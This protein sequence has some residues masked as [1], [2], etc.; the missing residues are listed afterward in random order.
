[1]SELTRCELDELEEDLKCMSDWAPRTHYLVGRLK[2][3]HAAQ[4]ET[5][6]QQA[7]RIQAVE[8]ERDLWFEQAHYLI[9]NADAPITW[10]EECLN[11]KQ[12]LA[13]LEAE[14]AA[15]KAVET[16]PSIGTGGVAM[17]RMNAMEIVTPEPPSC[18]H[19][20]LFTDPTMVEWV[21]GEDDHL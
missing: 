6:R 15:L 8:K 19:A 11:T 2:M 13:L 7:E 4:R 12:Q 14:L 21:V 10:E 16:P 5:I 3:E 20:P 1:M 17:K 18:T 9:P